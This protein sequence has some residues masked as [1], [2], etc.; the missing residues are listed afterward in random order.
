[1]KTDRFFIELHAGDDLVLIDM[2][3]VKVITGEENSCL[4]VVGLDE[5]FI[6][7]ETPREVVE[8]MHDAYV[9]V[10]T[11]GGLAKPLRTEDDVAMGYPR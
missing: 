4:Y 8:R 1:M 11:V 6:V 2:D 10:H 5:Q 9:R 7:D 3:D